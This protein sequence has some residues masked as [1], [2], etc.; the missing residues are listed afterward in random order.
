MK[1]IIQK[2]ISENSNKFNETSFFTHP[3]EREIEMRKNFLKGVG[4]IQNVINTCK[5]KQTAFIKIKNI[6]K[7]HSDIDIIA[8]KGDIKKILKKLRA[9]GF[10]ASTDLGYE[11]SVRREES[12]GLPIV[13]DLH[14]DIRYNNCNFLDPKTILKRKIN[15]KFNNTK[16]NFVSPEDDLMITLVHSMFQKISYFRSDYYD[17]LRWTEF[18]LNDI[19]QMHHA[20]SHK[21]FEWD[22]VLKTAKKYHWEDALTYSLIILNKHFP[23]KKIQNTIQG[24]ATKN[25]LKNK[26]K[27][28]VNN[29]SALPFY[30]SISLMYT[31]CLN[32]SPQEIKISKFK[33]LA[34]F[35]KYQKWFLVNF[36]RYIRNKLKK[37]ILK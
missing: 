7:P 9:L 22:Y 8:S 29:V 13:I 12:N 34:T 3:T 25:T 15:T 24:T 1:K 36:G 32:K 30:T 5:L 31:I 14:N 37:Q 10:V 23:D 27:K 18:T 35:L 20:A 17:K 26:M 16:I 33:G 21:N 28:D 11:Y 6:P 19:H 4:I 2:I